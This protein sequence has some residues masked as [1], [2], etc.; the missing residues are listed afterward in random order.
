[1][2]LTWQEHAHAAGCGA[3]AYMGPCAGGCPPTPT[4]PMH[5]PPSPAHPPLH[6]HTRAHTDYPHQEGAS[7]QLY[8]LHNSLADLDGLGVAVKEATKPIPDP[9][10]LILWDSVIILHSTHSMAER[11]P[12]HGVGC[13]GRRSTLVANANM[14]HR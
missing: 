12:V 8:P 3:T 11:N 13:R 7:L 9:K 1:M 2:L 14:H 10:D 6:P 5:A 4:P